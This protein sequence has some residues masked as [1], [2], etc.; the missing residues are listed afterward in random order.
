MQPT[1]A[2]SSLE[3]IASET[4][5]FVALAQSISDQ[6][7]TDP[8]SCAGWSI[9]ELVAHLAF[10]ASYYAE[11]VGDA[12]DG[13]PRP[14]WSGGGDVAHAQQRTL[15]GTTPLE[16]VAVVRQASE[17]LDAA[18]GRATSADL[19]IDAWHMRGPRPI[20]MYAAMRVYELGLH[21]WDLGKSL[22]TD[23]Q[24]RTDVALLLVDL[25]LDR[26][27]PQMLDTRAARDVSADVLLAFGTDQRVL[28]IEAGTAH[29]VPPA[30]ANP[31]VILAMSPQ[32][33]V[34]GMTGRL[35]WPAGAR[36]SGD[37]D[38]GRRIAGLFGVW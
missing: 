31:R 26:L 2:T 8:S 38:L 34:L 11:A 16:G 14:L 24:L 12:L 25:L 10:G 4:E 6:L 9:A 17:R 1:W 22:Q 30:E 18:L 13:T 29:G 23:V 5:Q 15:I 37:A 7:W 27:L 3:V 20:W 36:I 35:E 28:R 21:R 33:F 19:S 32:E